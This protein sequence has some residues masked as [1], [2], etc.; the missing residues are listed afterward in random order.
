MLVAIAFQRSLCRV[1]LLPTQK[2]MSSTLRS[3][4][5]PEKHAITDSVKD[6]IILHSILRFFK[7]G[8]LCV[9]DQSLSIFCMRNLVRSGKGSKR[10]STEY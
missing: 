6:F 3:V 8:K 1:A 9:Y 7:F 4:G 2:C 5:C 10:H